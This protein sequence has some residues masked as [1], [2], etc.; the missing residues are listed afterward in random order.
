[1]RAARA[2]RGPAKKSAPPVTAQESKDPVCGLQVNTGTAKFKSQHQGTPV[3][4][5][6]AGCKQAFDR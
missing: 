5:C 1:M 2:K 3:Y 4:F 6:S